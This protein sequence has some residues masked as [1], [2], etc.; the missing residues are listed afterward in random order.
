M[1]LKPTQLLCVFGCTFSSLCSSLR[2]PCYLAVRTDS[3]PSAFQRC[4]RWIPIGLPECLRRAHTTPDDSATSHVPRNATLVACVWSAM[5][6]HRRD[7]E[8]NER[9]CDVLR[10]SSPGGWLGSAAGWLACVLSLPPQFASAAKSAVC[11]KGGASEMQVID[12]L[13][14]EARGTQLCRLAL[15]THSQLPRSFREG[16]MGCFSWLDDEGLLNSLAW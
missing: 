9:T 4:Y 10:P 6:H 3:P 2:H 11:D 7:H 1:R 12:E 13:S 14:A 8:L 5:T 15:S 16:W